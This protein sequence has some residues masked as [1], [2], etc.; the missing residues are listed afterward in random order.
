M[1]FKDLSRFDPEEGSKFRAYRPHLAQVLIPANMESRLAA[2][3]FW[4]NLSE[5]FERIL[6]LDEKWFEMHQAPTRKNDVIVGSKNP[7]EALAC[8]KPTGP[9]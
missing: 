3:N 9:R 7:C 8:K 6:W 2:C 1:I 4:L 5:E